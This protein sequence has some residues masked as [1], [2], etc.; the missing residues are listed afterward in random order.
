MIEKV[1]IRNYRKFR[2]FELSLSPGLNTLVGGNDAGKSTLIEAITRV[3]GS[4]AP[5]RLV[6]RTNA[7]LNRARVAAT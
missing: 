2:E 4:Y 7:T 3:C 5:S 6:F 1:V